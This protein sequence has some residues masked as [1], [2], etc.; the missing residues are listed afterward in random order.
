MSQQLVLKSKN[1]LT[2]FSNIPDYV[3]YKQRVELDGGIIVNEQATIDA[4]MFIY[5]KG[6]NEASVFSA[7]NPSWGVKVVDGL[8]SKMYS[9]FS[10]AGDM[11]ANI[12]GN[13]PRFDTSLPVPT[14]YLQGSKST[15]FKSKGMF[16]SGIAASLSSI[17]V[18]VLS[19]YGTVPPQFFPVSMLINP[20]IPSGETIIRSLHATQLFR[21]NTTDNNPLNWSKRVTSIAGVVGSTALSPYTHGTNICAVSDGSTLKQ[22][23]SGL[24]LGTLADNTL[25]IP[26]RSTN[27]SA[28][29]GHAFGSDGVESSAYFLGHLAE[30]WVL[31][32]DVSAAAAISIR[33]DALYK[34]ALS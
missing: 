21:G 10:D 6:I 15:Y 19:S 32:K 27:N 25:N 9:L 18:P 5:Q 13:L 23:Q 14:V 3:A 34:T 28:Y 12:G 7:T 20:V 30:H 11:I 16:N 17:K 31:V 4:F 1:A 8:I 2:N 24:T 22:I 29:F 33:L 26:T